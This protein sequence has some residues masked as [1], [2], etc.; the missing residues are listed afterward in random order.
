M[1][2]A[3]AGSARR[4]ERYRPSPRTTAGDHGPWR[5]GGVLGQ[6]DTMTIGGRVAGLAALTGAAYAALRYYRNWGT[7]KAECQMRLPGD[8]LVGEPI[9]QATEAI[10]IDAPPAA[11]WPWLLQIGQ[12]RGGFYNHETLGRLTGLRFRNAERVHPEWQHLAVGDTV[13]AAPIGWL[14]YPDGVTY[15][16]TRIVTEEHLVLRAGTSGPPWNAVW[17]FHLTPAGLDGTRLLVRLRHGLRHPGEVAAVEALRPAA[18]L[19]IRAVLRGIRRRV[20][21]AGSPTPDAPPVAG[22]LNGSSR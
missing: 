22:A 10:S 14:G 19:G 11:V 16:V 4:T 20:E 1:D 9:V 6:T 12:D 7:T 5:T 21:Q 15:T 2:V 8:E 13:R 3:G 17:S 18:A